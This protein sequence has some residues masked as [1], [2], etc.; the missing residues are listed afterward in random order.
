MGLIAAVIATVLCAVAY[1]RMYKRELPEPIGKKQAAIPVALGV[2]SV[3]LMVPAFIGTGFLTA[4]ISG[5][6]AVLTSSPVLRSLVNA[7]FMAGFTEELIKLLMFL[8]V[9]LVV[10]PKNVYE[11][12]LLC[13]GVGFGFTGL[14][15]LIY[16]MTNPV[17]SVFRVLFFAMHMVFGLLMGVELGL[18]RF[19]KRAGTDGSVKHTLLALVLPVL[20]HTVFDASTTTNAG[21]SATEEHAQIIGIV[22]ALAVCAISIALQFVVLIRFKRDAEKLCGMSVVDDAQPAEGTEE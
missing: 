3:F 6:L 16:G 11:Y 14:E 22:V 8:I 4:S 21:L 1:V 18:A 15:D 7:F 2:V 10:K 20:W 17:G 13:A 9:V 5:S 19:N 12:G